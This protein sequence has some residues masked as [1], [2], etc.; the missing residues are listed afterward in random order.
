M[1]EQLVEMN[2]QVENHNEAIALFGVNDAN[3]KVIERELAVSI[4]TRGESVRVSGAD[5][6]VALVEKILQQL[7]AVIRKGV[8]ITERDVAYAIQLGRQGKIAHFEELYEEEIFKTAKGK[9]IR[10]KT[11]G[12]R[13]YIHA[14]KKN[15]IVFG[16]G[17]A[18][19]GKTYLAVV[20]AVRALKQGYVKK[21]IL[22][23]PAVEAGESLGFLPGDLKE[24]VDP[25]LRPLYDALHDILGQEYTQRMMERGTIE[26]AP[27]A[28]MRG[29]TLDDS[30]VILDEAQNTT[31]A[32]IKMFLTRLG[33]SSKMVVT[34]DPS[35]VDLPKGV[36]SGLSIAVNVLSGVSGLSFVK[37]EQSDVVRHPLVQRIIE[38]YDKME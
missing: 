16:I 17:P 28:Y 35:Q 21:I 5:E 36:K 4:V 31:G 15:D 37:L 14:L 6:A 29:R 26:I 23:R 8:S 19:T 30:F 13:Q 11:M 12:Q 22:T 10:V 34:G 24:K 33:F 2:Q 1:A 32:Q 25:Y 3:L 7:L 9:S 38:A 18:G 20:M 27:L